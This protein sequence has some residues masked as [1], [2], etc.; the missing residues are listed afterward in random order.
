M[1]RS[2]NLDPTNLSEIWDTVEGFTGDS[3]LKVEFDDK[4]EMSTAY[5]RVAEKGDATMFAFSHSMFEKWSDEKT[6][7]TKKAA[8]KKKPKVF[9]DKDGNLKVKVQVESLDSPDPE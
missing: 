7:E 1:F 3:S 2:P 9:V 4:T 5:M 6:V 8:K